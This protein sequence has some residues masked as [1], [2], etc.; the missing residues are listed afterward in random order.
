MWNDLLSGRREHLTTIY[1]QKFLLTSTLL[2]PISFHGSYLVYFSQHKCLEIIEKL[3]QKHEGRSSV[4]VLNVIDV[5]RPCLSTWFSK[6]P[7]LIPCVHCFPRQLFSIASY[8]FFFYNI[9]LGFLAGLIRILKGLLLG[10]VFMAR[11]DRTCLMQGYQ[12]WDKGSYFNEFTLH[13]HHHY[14]YRCHHHCYHHRYRYDRRHHHRRHHYYRF[15]H[16]FLRGKPEKILLLLTRSRTYALP[17]T[18]SGVFCDGDSGK[19]HWQKTKCSEQAIECT[20]V[21][22][23]VQVCFAMVIRR[24]LAKVQMLRTRSQVYDLITSLYA[25]TLMMMKTALTLTMMAMT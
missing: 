11:I 20:A 5:V 10:I 12:T 8:F 21:R 22:L 24:N 4:D 17:I 18:G 14:H 23:P 7:S 3:L 2:I 13:R 6:C 15:Y 9:I 1:F 16:H 25:L 19:L